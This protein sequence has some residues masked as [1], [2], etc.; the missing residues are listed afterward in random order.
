[1][2]IGLQLH[3]ADFLVHLGSQTAGSPENHLTLFNEHKTP[4]T[5]I[6]M[7][8]LYY[9]R[10]MCILF[11]DTYFEKTEILLEIW[12]VQFETAVH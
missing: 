11:Q 1:M 4:K 5:K 8:S 2:S 9:L 12:V 7:I 6:Q 3:L 10:H